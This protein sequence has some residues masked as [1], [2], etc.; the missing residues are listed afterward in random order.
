MSDLSPRDVDGQFYALV[1]G[2]HLG[3]A[4]PLVAAGEGHPATLVRRLTPKDEDLSGTRA[5]FLM[6]TFDKND[7]LIAYGWRTDLRLLSHKPTEVPG[8]Q[9]LGVQIVDECGYY[10]GDRTSVISVVYSR[11]W[12]E[13]LGRV[14][15]SG[16]ACE[17][18]DAWLRGALDDPNEPVVEP[19]HPVA[20]RHHVLGA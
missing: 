6:T 9:Q 1:G 5:R 8:L 16:A 10:T 7:N 11:I 3:G 14:R 18:S 13:D 2:L 19:L 20:G 17:P 4:E 15:R 12:V